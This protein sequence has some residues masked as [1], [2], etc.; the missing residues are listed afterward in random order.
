MSSDD[1]GNPPFTSTNDTLI[2][3][4]S[5]INVW[6]DGS[7][8]IYLIGDTLGAGPN[9]LSDYATFSYGNG[10]GAAPGIYCIDC[11]FTS[12]AAETSTDMLP[13]GTN[14]QQA[15]YFID[16]S[17]YGSVIGA[18][19]EAISG[20]TVTVTSAQ[21]NTECSTTTG[22]TGAFSC[23]MVNGTAGNAIV[24]LDVA[25]T[26][27][28]VVTTQHNPHILKAAAAGC[29]TGSNSLSVTDTTTGYVVTLAGC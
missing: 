2:G 10:G 4:Q 5:S 15:Q 27:G 7:G 20:A 6:W 8:L 29:T 25:N 19:G 24:K 1:V 26:T 9:P 28:P 17:L 13:E 3:P 23:T 11:V 12:P 18:S 21:G 16:Y 22:S 14:Q